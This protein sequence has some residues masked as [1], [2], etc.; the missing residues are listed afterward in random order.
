MTLEEKY[1]L[2]CYEEVSR[3]H[4]SKDIWLVRHNETEIFYVK[5]RIG[6]YNKAVYLRLMQGKFE[7]IP[8][9][10]M[11]VEEADKLILIEVYIHCASL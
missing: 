6:L 3:L 11:C 5:K 1:E 8:Q 7:N 4:E 2:S 10:I 9:I